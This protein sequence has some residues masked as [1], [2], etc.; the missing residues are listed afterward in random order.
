MCRIPRQPLPPPH[1]HGGVDWSYMWVDI[2][3]F[4]LAS[5]YLYRMFYEGDHPLMFL[6]AISSGS[7]LVCRWCHLP[8]S[9]V[10]GLSPRVLDVC[11]LH[12]I[13][14]VPVLNSLYMYRML[15][16]AP[17]PTG[18]LPLRGLLTLMCLVGTTCLSAGVVCKFSVTA[19]VHLAGTAALARLLMYVH[20]T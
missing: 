10:F 8:G 4:T 1:P 18:Y 13:T 11:D 12:F 17:P 20:D 15:L 2:F 5:F 16:K 7:L 14:V 9:P 6:V 19:P 3:S